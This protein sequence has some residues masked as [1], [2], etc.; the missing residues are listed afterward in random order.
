MTLDHEASATAC[1]PAIIE[2]LSEAVA[3]QGFPVK[4]LPSGAGHDAMAMAAL[5]P[6]GMI[7][8]RCKGGISHNPLED[9]T[10]ED[11]DACLRV[12]IDYVRHLDATALR[13]T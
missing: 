9:I 5:C 12:L 1:S 3:R 7:F 2:E 8:V 4:R 11:A 10:T 13:A 6:V